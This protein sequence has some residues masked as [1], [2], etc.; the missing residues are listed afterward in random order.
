MMDGV[1]AAFV[2]LMRSKSVAVD[3]GTLAALSGFMLDTGWFGDSATAEGLLQRATARGDTF[4]RHAYARWLLSKHRASVDGQKARDLLRMSAKEG[5]PESQ[6]MLATLCESSLKPSCETDEATRQLALAKAA[7][8][9]AEMEWQRSRILAHTDL[10]IGDDN[11]AQHALQRAAELGSLAA[12]TELADRLG[13]TS[14]KKQRR[15]ATKWRERAAAQEYPP[16]IYALAETQASSDDPRE[17]AKAIANYR[18]AIELGDSSSAVELGNAYRNGKGV[19]KDDQEAARL[20][21]LG[22][23]WGNRVAQNNLAVVLD[24]GEGVTTDPAAARH[25]YLRSLLQGHGGGGAGL[26]DIYQHGRGVRQDARIAAKY[27]RWGAEL[28]H[29]GSQNAL[30]DLLWNGDGV[31][32]NRAEAVRWY[33]KASAQGNLDAQFSLAY[34]Y[35]FGDG[36]EQSWERAVT[37]YRQCA[38]NGNVSC[39]HDLGYILLHGP[40]PTTSPGP[41]WRLRTCCSKQIPRYATK[42]E[43]WNL[44]KPVLPKATRRAPRPLGSISASGAPQRTRISE[45]NGFKKVRMPAIGSPPISWAG[46]P[47]MARA[48]SPAMQARRGGI[49]NKRRCRAISQAFG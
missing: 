13:S 18:R 38:E 8:G 29:A 27:F 23:I 7:Y 11:K 32:K 28:G 41:R 30:G 20:Y 49:W 46:A 9:P 45:C 19:A 2:V 5:L 35:R 26:G 6:I 24:R 47:T 1:P 17:R 34:A 31:D 40:E 12:M 33:A 14:E 48:A 10:V 37:G 15:E 44:R 16:A 4:G 21:R 36:V 42:S 22:A 3:A 43:A 25:W 39:Q